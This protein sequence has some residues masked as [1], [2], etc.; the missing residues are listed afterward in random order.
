MPDVE[1]TERHVPKPQTFKIAIPHADRPRIRLALSGRGDVR[2]HQTNRPGHVAPAD[3]M[4]LEY[5]Y[6]EVLNSDDV[7][8]TI[9]KN[10]H[11]VT[12]D[13]LKA[14]IVKELSTM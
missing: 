2:L 8:F 14:H 4:G 7:E 12:V 13:E 9:T 11:N 5:D 1:K 10:P 3:A 6:Q